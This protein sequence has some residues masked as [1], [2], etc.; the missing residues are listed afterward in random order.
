MLMRATRIQFVSVLVAA[1]LPLL[2]S[3]AVAV[4]EPGGPGNGPPATP[5]N[6]DPD[7]PPTDE[8]PDKPEPEK[9]EPDTKAPAKPTLGDPTVEPDGVV[10]LPVSGEQGAQLVVKEGAEL[11]DEGRS[12]GQPR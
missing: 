6:P 5:G 11:I 4:E 12:T 10:K 2:G 9:P 3:V 7:E 8:K 1:S